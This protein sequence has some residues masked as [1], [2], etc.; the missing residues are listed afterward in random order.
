[1][2]AATGYSRRGCTTRKTCEENVVF[3]GKI[4]EESLGRKS[5]ESVDTSGK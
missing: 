3:G 5:K 4:D 2:K 1:V